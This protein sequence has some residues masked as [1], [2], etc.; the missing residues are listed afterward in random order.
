MTRFD[1]CECLSVV[2][3]NINDST[4]VIHKRSDYTGY[5]NKLMSNWSYIQPEIICNL[6]ETYCCS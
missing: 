5:F 2:Q 6:F 4:D 3:C 1:I